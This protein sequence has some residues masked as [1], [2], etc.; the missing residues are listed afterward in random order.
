MSAKT[1]STRKGCE[2][3]FVCCVLWSCAL[4]LSFACLALMAVD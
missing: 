1:Y 3:S 4:W 2:V